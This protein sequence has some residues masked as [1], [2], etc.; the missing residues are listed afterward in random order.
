[1]LPRRDLRRIRTDGEIQIHPIAK[2]R[3]A[4]SPAQ[5][6]FPLQVESINTGSAAQRSEKCSKL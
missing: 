6:S 1:M 5:L 2:V 4:S 3:R